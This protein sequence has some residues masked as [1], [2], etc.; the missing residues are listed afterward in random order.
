MYAELV[1]VRPYIGTVRTATIKPVRLSGGVRVSLEPETDAA[2][3]ARDSRCRRIGSVGHQPQTPT[4]YAPG[5][6]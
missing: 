4:S 2:W 3:I 5:L 6:F 1:T